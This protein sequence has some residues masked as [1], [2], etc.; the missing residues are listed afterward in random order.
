[1]PTAEPPATPTPQVEVPPQPV[2]E[3]SITNWRVSDAPKGAAVGEFPS[4]TK[5]VY[6]VFEY[7]YMAGEEVEIRV[8]D[9]VGNIL[10]E[11]TR[12]LSGDGTESI[13]F[14]AGGGGLAAGRYLVNIY[15]NEV[16]IRTMIWDVAE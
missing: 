16:V 2:P 11:K 12:T 9:S 6:I 8:Y 5:K 3:S 14:S 10:S 13:S 15:K 4:G 7:A 1:M